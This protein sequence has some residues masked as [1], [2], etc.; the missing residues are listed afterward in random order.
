MWRELINRV[1]IATVGILAAEDSRDTR[2][3]CPDPAYTRT[4]IKAA[5]TQL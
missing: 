3:N 2:R 5:Q 4:D 1:I